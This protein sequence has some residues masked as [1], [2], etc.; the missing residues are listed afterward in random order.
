MSP[1]SGASEFVSIMLSSE[2]VEGDRLINLEDAFAPLRP[3][4]F[5]FFDSEIF[6]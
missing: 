5:V 4:L 2:D 6:G 3:L 1:G